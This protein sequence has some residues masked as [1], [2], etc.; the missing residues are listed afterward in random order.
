MKAL[1]QFTSERD[2]GFLYRADI[3]SAAEMFSKALQIDDGLNTVIR[4]SPTEAA[5]KLKV[6]GEFNFSTYNTPLSLILKSFRV[7]TSV[8]STQ[9]VFVVAVPP[10]ITHSVCRCFHSRFE[11]NT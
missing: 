3:A 9:T 2:G 7:F 4:K 8:C 11:C 1:S 5:Q 6:E 10:G